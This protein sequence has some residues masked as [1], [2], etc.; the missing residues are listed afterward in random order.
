MASANGSARPSSH[1]AANAGSGSDVRAVARMRSACQASP[2]SPAPLVSRA[3][4]TAPSR[5]TA[6]CGSS[7][8][9]ATPA[10]PP[11]RGR[12]ARPRSS[13]RHRL[14]A[15]GAG[16]HRLE[17]PG[18]MY[19]RTSALGRRCTV[20]ITAGA[21]RASGSR[22][23]RRSARRIRL[24]SSNCRCSTSDAGDH[25][26]GGRIPNR[27]G[28]LLV[29]IIGRRPDDRLLFTVISTGPS[30]GAATPG[31]MA[32]SRATASSPRFWLPAAPRRTCR[33]GAWRSAG[34]A[35]RSCWLG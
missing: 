7:S 16:W 35:H 12:C 17:P 14:P 23:S 11:P 4:S 3:A 19:R 21:T 2:I 27:A 33:P 28:R 20:A 25:R 32:S 1:A 24:M 31:T 18:V 13:A 10:R 30:C 9:K 6:Q 15:A 22:S 5:R 29:A 26:A 34:Q 8:A